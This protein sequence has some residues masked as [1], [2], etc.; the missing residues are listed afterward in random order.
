MNLVSWIKKNPAVTII[1]AIV[2]FVLFKF[3]TNLPQRNTLMPS[4][5]ESIRSFD[6]A[7]SYAGQTIS[8]E[9]TQNAIGSMPLSQPDAPPT[10]TSQRMVVTNSYLSLLVINVV[11]TRDR[12]QQHVD[13]LGGYMVSSSTS[14]PNEQANATITFR[15]PSNNLPQTLEF[16]RLQAVKVVS[17]KLTGTDVTDEYVDIDT[18]IVQLEQTK[19]KMKELLNKAT[20]VSDLVNITSQI[21]NIQQQIDS[22]KGKQIALSQNAQLSKITVY[23]STDELALPYAPENPF[24][25]DV[26][27]KLAVRSLLTKLQEVASLLIWVTV[28]SVIWLPILIIGFIVYR[29]FNKRKS[30]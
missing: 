9:I 30:L 21:T 14:N 15:I 12:L 20:E 16:F 7:D 19:T 4:S 3:S 11:E 29:W 6:Y 5:I 18:R 26:I 10:L 23:L 22:L 2:L 13:S 24:R 8:K 27:F 28:Y 25:P 1:I 17:E